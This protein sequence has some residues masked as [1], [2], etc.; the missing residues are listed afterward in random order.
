M[1]NNKKYSIVIVVSEFNK[2]VSEALLDGAKRAFHDC[3]G[4]DLKIFR[5][6][7][8]FEIASAVKVSANKLKPDAIVTLGCVIR[9]ETKHFDFISSE[10]T[11]SIQ[12]LTLEFDIPIMFGVLTTE[13]KQQAIERSLKKDKGYEVMSGA[14]QMIKTFE[15]I[16][17][18]S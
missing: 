7:G 10:C 6:P 12:D 8:A 5:V 16:K 15:E 13:N 2:S 18:S 17:K 11:R 4:G 1:I 9:G 3:G 14:F